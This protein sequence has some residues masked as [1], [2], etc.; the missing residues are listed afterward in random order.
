MPI[1]KSRVYQGNMGSETA[2]NDMRVPGTTVRPEPAF[3]H[4]RKY[5]GCLN[6]SSCCVQLN[7]SARSKK[8]TP[9][10]IICSIICFGAE[11]KKAGFGCAMAEPKP[12]EE[13]LSY[14]RGVWRYAWFCPLWIPRQTIC[15]ALLMLAAVLIVQPVQ[16]TGSRTCCS[17]KT[18]PSR[19]RTN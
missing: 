1:S 12:A 13:E 8:I 11:R 6:V 3:P 16:E 7:D 10:K 19:Q 2:F 17:G 15:P 9:G 14:W 4:T 5:S 18:P